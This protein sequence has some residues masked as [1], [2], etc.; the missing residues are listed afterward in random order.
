MVHC[1]TMFLGIGEVMNLRMS[2][3]IALWMTCISLMVGLW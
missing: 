3:Y 1:M 2:S